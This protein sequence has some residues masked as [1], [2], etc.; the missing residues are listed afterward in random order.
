[1]PENQLADLLLEASRQ[2]GKRLQAAIPDSPE[3]VQAQRD[4]VRL[5]ADYW[6]EMR[7]TWDAADR[8]AAVVRRARPAVSAGADTEDG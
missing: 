6:E 4:L 1:M 8:P 7:T 2:A 3:W 5:R